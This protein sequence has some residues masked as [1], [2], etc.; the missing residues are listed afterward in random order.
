[1]FDNPSDMMDTPCVSHVSLTGFNSFSVPV[2][3]ASSIMVL[4]LS[5]SGA[6][7]P[8]GPLFMAVTISWNYGFLKTLN[9]MPLAQNA[10]ITLISTVSLAIVCIASSIGFVVLPLPPHLIFSSSHAL[11]L[12]F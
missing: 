11:F 5:Y 1:M 8:L 9:G 7:Y 6:L 3:H 12:K 2:L 10:L 4:H